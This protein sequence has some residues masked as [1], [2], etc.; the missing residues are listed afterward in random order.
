[1]KFK[2]NKNIKIDFFA[3]EVF[4]K[5]KAVE[6]YAE[7]IGHFCYPISVL[8][9]KYIGVQVFILAA[10]ISSESVGFNL[11]CSACIHDGVTYD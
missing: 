7:E 9:C 4:I 11:V 10:Q 8:I 3:L 6:P 2:Q 1:L 5:I